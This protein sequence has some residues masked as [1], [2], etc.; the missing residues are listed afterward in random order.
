MRRLL[1]ILIA[2]LIPW[3]VFATTTLY[4]DTD[5]VS[6]SPPTYSTLAAAVAALPATLADDYVIGCSG[7]TADTTSV[8][9]SGFITTATNDLT[10]RGEGFGVGGQWD[11]SKYRLDAISDIHHGVIHID[12]EVYLTVEDMQIKATAVNSYSAVVSWTANAANG[13]STFNR[14]LSVYD[15]AGYGSSIGW[16]QY[17]VNAAGNLVTTIK[18]TIFTVTPSGSSPYGIWGESNV[19]IYNCVFK[20]FYN[21]IK[22][23][24]GLAT[25]TNTAAFDNVGTD[26]NTYNAG[27][28][29][30]DHCASDDGDGTN[31]VVPTD[32]TAV[33]EDHVNGDFRL[34]A[35]SD[36]IGAGIDL[37]AYFTDD[38]TGATRE[39][40]WDIGAFAYATATGW[41]GKIYGITPAKIMGVP[42]SNISKVGGL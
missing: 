4:V 13:T 28:I 18:N 24:A 6:P 8:T 41:A 23:N 36:L 26:F 22:L 29:A 1:L 5:A 37:S 31:A 38:I 11:T 12:A 33:F 25:I 21:A 16:D 3:Q 35:G 30:I 42:V 32:W 19:Y 40:P 15:P 7:T 39:I 27:S 10:I 34:K 14:C 2:L 17:L 9:L 20:G